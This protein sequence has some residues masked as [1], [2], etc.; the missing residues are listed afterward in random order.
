MFKTVYPTIKFE[1]EINVPVASV[2]SKIILQERLCTSY[3]G[4]EGEFVP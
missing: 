2:K 1:K 3:V 4:E